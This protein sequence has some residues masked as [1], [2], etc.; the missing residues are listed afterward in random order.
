MPDV[1]TERTA[2]ETSIAFDS[3]TPVTNIFMRLYSCQEQ[4]LI[5]VQVDDVLGI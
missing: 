5:Y 3:S 2:Q 4:I 1:K